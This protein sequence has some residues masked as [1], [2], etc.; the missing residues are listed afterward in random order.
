ML[1]FA[2]GPVMMEQ[3]ILDMASE[4]LPY[5]RTSEFLALMLENE[6]LLKTAVA[7][8][9][10]SR[11]VFLT[12]SGTAAMEAAVINLFNSKDKLLIVNGGSFG[13]RFQQICGI[14]GL[15]SESIIL[16]YGEQLSYEHLR[17]YAKK[18]FTGLLINVHETST[19]VLY[20]MEL[21]RDFCVDNDL[22]LVAD[23]ISSFMADPYDMEDHGVNATILSSQKGLALPPGISFVV[24][25]RC[26]QERIGDNHVQSLYFDFKTYLIDGERGQ[27]PYTP[28]L[29]ILLQ[30]R[31]RLEIIEHLGI[32]KIIQRTRLVAEDFRGKIDGLP[33]EIAH[34]SLSNALTP[35]RPKGRMKANEIFEHLKDE[36]DIFVCP[37]GG[38]LRDTLFRV[39]HMGS[40]S[41]VDNDKLVSAFFDMERKG[42]L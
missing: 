28:A 13:K 15:R 36:Y 4:Q 41:L 37:N 40:I 30:L 21:V 23:A 22:I 20:D 18:G 26:A 35:L 10:S 24:L 9:S 7:A 25:D 2:V 12:G 8:P 31:K 38:D 3:E 1:N 6:E 34:S 11:I 29:G 39:G 32:E 16:E 33:L 17:P 42:V 27:T 14:H 19:G 5:F